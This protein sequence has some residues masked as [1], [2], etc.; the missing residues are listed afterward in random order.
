MAEDHRKCFVIGPIGEDGT[1]ER[2]NADWVLGYIIK[3]VLES[4]P[5]NYGVARAD[6]GPPG[7]ITAQLIS[8]IFEADL[9]VADL[10]GHNANV[11]YELA[12]SHMLKKPVV[13]LITEGERV[14]FDVHDD[15][16][17]PYNRHTPH[18]LPSFR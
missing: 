11:F 18:I 12:I 17:I 4:E 13:S 2:V 10:T 15:R 14:P 16:A 8:D 5:F 6:Q 1:P 7:L 3:P 9:I